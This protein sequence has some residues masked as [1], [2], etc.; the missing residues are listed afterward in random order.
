[1]AAEIED[2]AGSWEQKK[3]RLLLVALITACRGWMERRRTRNS[4][5]E[6]TPDELRDIGMT[7]EA[8][9]AEVAKSWFWR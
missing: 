7:R 8:A 5:S 3:P 4:L 6:L 9:R 1:M 2:I